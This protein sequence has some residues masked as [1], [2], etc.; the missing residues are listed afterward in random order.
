MGRSSAVPEDAAG[1]VVDFEEAVGDRN[2]PSA[3]AGIAGDGQPQ[4]APGQ[5]FHERKLGR[6]EMMLAME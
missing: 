6:D 3:A 1:A 4:G 5:L 2:E